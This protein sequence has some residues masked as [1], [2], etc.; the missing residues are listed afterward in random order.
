MSTATLTPPPAKT[1]DRSPPGKQKKTFLVGLGIL[2]GLTA[3]AL[4]LIHA[5][6][7]E[8]TDNAYTTANVH[9]ISSR[10]SGTV[11]E[12]KVDD[13]EAVKQGQ[14]LLR[15]DPRDFQVSVDKA[16]AAYD[17]ALADF[18]RVEALKSDNAISRQE[19]DQAQS[20]MQITKAELDDCR[21]Q[22]SYC[23]IVA[24]SDG[25]I[26]NKTVQTGNRIPVGGSLMAVVED[27]WVVA[28]YKETQV[29]NMKKGQKVK[30]H[31]DA[32]S[33]KTF[34]GTIDSFSPGSGSIFALLP[35]ENATGNFTK[36]VQRI[37]VKIRFDAESLHGHEQQ[38]VPGLSVQTDIDLTSLDH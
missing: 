6:R 15:L 30:I 24:P 35:P 1:T 17:R 25:F 31:I 38:I 22:L 10:V 7:H 13:N 28:N 26:G 8:T 20:N 23:D 2:L 12:V 14:V 27:L 18:N 19:Y 16:Q 36:I 32:L 37:P 3:V 29:G 33:G 21:N 4:Y 9:T 34:T 11:I 5:A